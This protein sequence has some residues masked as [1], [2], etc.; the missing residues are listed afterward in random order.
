MDMRL[1]PGWIHYVTDYKREYF[2]LKKRI[3]RAT[4]PKVVE[5]AKKRLAELNKEHAPIIN[6]WRNK[7]CWLPKINDHPEG[8]DTVDI[9][10]LDNQ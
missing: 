3:S 9:S 2:R 6:E 7:L 8:W 10:W 4:S 5:E 1:L